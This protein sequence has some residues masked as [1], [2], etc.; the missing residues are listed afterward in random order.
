MRVAGLISSGPVLLPLVGN[1]VGWRRGRRGRAGVPGLSFIGS[2]LWS[3]A[4]YARFVVVVELP[5]NPHFWARGPY[6][7]V[8]LPLPPPL[9]S[10]DLRLPSSYRCRGVA[11]GTH[12]L[13]TVGEEEGRVGQEWQAYSLSSP[14]RGTMISVGVDLPNSPRIRAG[15]SWNGSPCLFLHRHPLTTLGHPLPTTIAE[16]QWGKPRSDASG[17][18]AR[19]CCVDIIVFGSAASSGPPLVLAIW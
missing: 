15:D 16:S 5:D 10:D 11:V 8:P 19:A 14:S 17:T 18:G 6:N 2:W 1:R 7:V 13:L 4:L 3:D 12:R 9:P